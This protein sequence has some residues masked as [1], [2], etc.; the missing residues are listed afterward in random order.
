M[1][2]QYKFSETSSTA[3]EQA[4][5]PCAEKDAGSRIAC[6]AGSRIACDA[7]PQTKKNEPNRYALLRYTLLNVY[8]RLFSL[9][10]LANLAVFIAIMVT[11]RSLLAFVNAIA[12]NLL[13]CGLARHQVVVNTL[14]LT[15]C[16]IPRSA[17]LRL[18]CIAAKVFHYG[19]VHSG[20]G[21]ASFVWYIGL[22]VLVTQKYVAGAQEISTAVLAL[23]YVIL[24]LLA[25]IIVVAYPKFRVKCHDY[26]EL[27]H[28]F[29]G[30]MILGLFLAL[31]LVFGN[32]AR[33]VE[34]RTLG[35]YLVRLPAFWFLMVAIVAT[36][37]PWLMLR[38]VPVQSEVLSKHAV[39]LRFDYAPTKL[40]KGIQLSKHP[41]RDW[42]GFATFPNPDNKSFSVLVS[43]AGDWTAD[44]INNPPTHLWKRGVRLYGFGYATRMFRK[45]VV[46]TT[47]SGIGPCLSFLGEDNHPPFRVVWQTRSPL[48]TY[49]QDVLD[50]VHRMDTNPVVIDTNKSGRVDMLPIAMQL[51]K[52]FQAEAVFVISN[53]VV[54]KNLV[55]AL[56]ARGIPAFGPIFDS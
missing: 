5:S 2:D 31:L 18:R 37:H 24:V 55:F 3:S 56:E 50:M 9:I 17:P 1:S 26:F 29:A 20:C 41:L 36:V 44:A 21:V 7:E 6:D 52:D 40:A 28:R 53:A 47:G 42:H 46:V 12:A 23:C 48:Q 19:G 22:M 15:L 39:R 43:K 11:D 25:S 8:R 49:G 10:F 33:Q 30:W 35:G 38:K 34:N 32:N 16:C 45:I 13:V 4:S 14:F 51:V 27:T 54:T